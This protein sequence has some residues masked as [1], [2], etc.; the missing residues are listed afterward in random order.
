MIQSPPVSLELQKLNIPHRVFTHPG[1][2]TSLEQAARER[3]QRP[4]QIVRSILFRLSEDEYV[5]A[6]VAGPAQ[7]SWKALRSHLGQSRL[8][9]A[10]KDEVLEVTGYP[11]G[12][13]S[14]FGTARRLRVL[15]DPSVFVE[16]EISLGSGV[17][18]TTIILKS[19]DLK[20]ALGEVEVAE[21]LET[22]S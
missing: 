13:V 1:K 17:R 4:E 15:V 11:I 7:I 2:I 6:L 19:A 16:E 9:M 10:D 12:A 14:P 20:R 8:T 5:M 21:L 22:S 3:G 18:G